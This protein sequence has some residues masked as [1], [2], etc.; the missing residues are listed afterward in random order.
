M[1]SIQEWLDQLIPMSQQLEAFML[2]KEPDDAFGWGEM[3]G[4]MWAQMP[5]ERPGGLLLTGPAGCGKH[6]AAAHML[7][8]LQQEGYGTVFLDGMEL[9]DWDRK[10]AKE[11]LNKLLDYF[12]DNQQPLCLVVENLESCGCRWEML[13][14]LGRTLQMNRLYRDQVEYP[15]F[16][17]LIDQKEHQ[18]PAS[19][20]GELRLCRM[21]LPDQ[22][23]RKK[24][25]DKQA[26][27]IAGYVSLDMVAAETQGMTYAQL[28]DLVYNLQYL[29]DCRDGYPTQ[30]EV[31]AFLS[32]QTPP[33]SREQKL[34]AFL[35]TAQKFMEDMPQMLRNAAASMPVA[36]QASA[37]PQMITMPQ[38]T[39]HAVTT[40]EDVGNRRAEIENMPVD[41]LQ[42]ETFGQE[43]ID[44][45]TAAAQNLSIPQ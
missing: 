33:A 18:I 39:A 15:L 3:L 45:M 23:R 32:Q 19:L 20:R 16:L 40:A 9:Q 11:R 35:G 34:E 29:V 25:L 38:P 26:V 30:E 21:C 41:Q 7:L 4:M 36:A 42:L 14:H 5:E 12:Y 24:Y 43:F 37:A 10:T 17:I 28:A 1:D 8:Q 22:Q 31:Q 2:G 44:Q 27:S 13:T 6:T